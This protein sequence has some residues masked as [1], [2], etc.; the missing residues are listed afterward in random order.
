MTHFLL[1]LVTAR[2]AL[3]IKA[4]CHSSRS[5]FKADSTGLRTS[6][7]FL[8]VPLEIVVLHAPLVLVHLFLCLSNESPALVLGAARL[9]PSVK[10]GRNA[11]AW[12]PLNDLWVASAAHRSARRRTRRKE[13]A[14]LLQ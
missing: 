6:E 5:A 2:A 4:K 8:A 3:A 9:I 7:G 13:H 11:V 1:C 10:V 12:V 14:W